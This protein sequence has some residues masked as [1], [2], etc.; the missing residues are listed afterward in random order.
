MTLRH[1]SN[2]SGVTKQIAEEYGDAIRYFEKENGGVSSALNCGIRHM[3]GTYF[4]W[5]SHDDFYDPRKIE[6]EVAALPEEKQK[7]VVYC[8]YAT[9]D[10][11]S[12]P[13][14]DTKS[15][16]RPQHNLSS[17]EAL[18]HVLRH[19][20]L[21]GC[22]F[23]IPCQA[24]TECGLFDEDLRYAQDA[25]MWYRLFSN[26]WGVVVV[27]K[28]Q[29]VKSRVHQN[30]QTQKNRAKFTL[31]NQKVC[32]RIAPTFNIISTREEDFVLEYAIRNAIKQE[33]QNVRFC[34]QLMK[35]SGRLTCSASTR[36][37][38]MSAYGSV[39]P[40]IRKAYYRLFRKIQTQ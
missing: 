25:L 12:A 28:D 2:D 32:Q 23:L 17:H 40:A 35:K 16:G 18:H 29:L 1:G 19:G 5:L 39:R 38:F 13:M 36:L 3:R 10:S 7:V 37:M 31:D 20:S 27:V 4:S 21:N 15:S 9:V 6:V 22:G 24:F 14:P 11:N 34:R 26:G 33:R 8:N 30:Q